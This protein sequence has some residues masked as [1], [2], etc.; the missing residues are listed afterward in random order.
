MWAIGWALTAGA[1]EVA[2]APVDLAQGVPA[3]LATTP[4]E[5]GGVGAEAW[6]AL[7]ARFRTNLGCTAVLDRRDL[8]TL[9]LGAAN[10]VSLS[11]PAERDRLL[12]VYVRLAPDAPRRFSLDSRGSPIG[13]IPTEETQAALAAADPGGATA[14]LLAGAPVWVD[15]RAAA[16]GDVVSLS[17]GDH[18]VQSIGRGGPRTEVLTATPGARWTT[19]SRGPSQAARVALGVGGGALIAGGVA[20]LVWGYG[21]AQRADEVDGDLDGRIGTW[22]GLGLGLTVVGTTGLALSAA[23]GPDDAV[24]VRVMGALP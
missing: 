20:S 5:P 24:S 7:E 4:P 8:A 17:P 10:V 19:T 6:L 9:Y 16:P 22:L 2:C 11:D 1:A 13:V 18:L 21:P 3:L 15:G 12:E 23:W 14:S